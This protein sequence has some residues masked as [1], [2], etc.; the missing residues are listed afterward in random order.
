MKV[1]RRNFIKLGAVGGFAAATNLLAPA[2]SA[3]QEKL[4]ASG[5]AADSLQTLA[6]ANFRSAVGTEFSLLNLTDASE[7]AVAVLSKVNMVKAT[8]KSV[9]RG[10]EAEKQ[11]GTA[12]ENFT[13]SFRLPAESLSQSTYLVQHASLG[14]RRKSSARRHQQNLKQLKVKN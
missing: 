11:R 2:L 13:L 3:A 1:S 5:V 10:G 9:R 14:Q 12:A 4:G 8:G 6:S 7:N